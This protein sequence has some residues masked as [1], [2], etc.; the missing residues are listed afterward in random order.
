MSEKET[1]EHQEN[2][3]S[4]TEKVPEEQEL[5][6]T[7]HTETV[8]KEK[9]SDKQKRGPGNPNFIRRIPGRKKETSTRS[10][11]MFTDE[12]EKMDEMLQFFRTAYNDPQLG[13]DDLIR[14][15]YYQLIKHP[16]SVPF[17]KWLLQESRENFKTLEF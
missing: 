7:E 5:L 12:S 13:Y 3:N 4:T 10:F 16:Y 1:L 8:E 6:E 14:M 2:E 15:A 17:K 9:E 11:K